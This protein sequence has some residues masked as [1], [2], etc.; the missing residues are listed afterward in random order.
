LVHSL[1][2]WPFTDMG[3]FQRGLSLTLLVLAGM[4]STIEAFRHHQR[5]EIVVLAAA[6]GPTLFVGVR[7]LKLF[8]DRKSS[9]EDKTLWQPQLTR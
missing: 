5:T 7:T 1:D 9:K 3:H 4:I 6:F 8:L 2:A